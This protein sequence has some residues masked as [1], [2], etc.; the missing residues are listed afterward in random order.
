MLSVNYI[1]RL[2][3]IQ[4]LDRFTKFEKEEDPAPGPAEPENS[5]KSA[6]DWREV[7]LLKTLLDHWEL[8]GITAYM[9]GTPFSVVNAGSANGIGAADNAGVGNALGLGSYPDRIGNPNG[10]KPIVTSTGSNI[11]PLLLNPGAFA[12]PRGLPLATPAE[13]SLTIRPAPTSTCR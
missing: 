2:P 1:Y 7:A 8:S 5:E 13:T 6:P 3:L 12:A 10:L 11:G 4:L 9:T